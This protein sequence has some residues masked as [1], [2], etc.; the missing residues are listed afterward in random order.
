[1]H[2]T[3]VIRRRRQQNRLCASRMQSLGIP[4]RRNLGSTVFRR[5][6]SRYDANAM[7]EQ[8]PPAKLGAGPRLRLD[9]IPDTGPPVAPALRFGGTQ[10]N[11]DRGST[12]PAAGLRTS[13]PVLEAVN[14]SPDHGPE[15]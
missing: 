6:T 12:S 14:P 15:D 13:K 3:G 8:A 10:V 4:I 2:R 11:S 9:F 1:M 5:K 7:Q